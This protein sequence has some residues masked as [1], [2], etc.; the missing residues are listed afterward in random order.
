M[1]KETP[2][3]TPK[4]AAEPQVPRCDRCGMRFVAVECHGH[5][6]CSHCG[7]LAVGGECCQG[8]QCQAS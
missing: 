6:Q 2:I 3:E 4:K 7:Q 8:G 5:I 1:S